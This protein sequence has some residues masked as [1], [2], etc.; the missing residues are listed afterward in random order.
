MKKI[1]SYLGAGTIPC[2]IFA[3]LFFMGQFD[4][5]SSRRTDGVISQVE[6]N[7]ARRQI[8]DSITAKYT[9]EMLA[10]IDSVERF[11]EKK[12]KRLK[13]E[14]RQLE[15][16]IVRQ[17]EGYESDSMYNDPECASV[18]QRCDSILAL[19]AEYSD[20]LV[21]TI[22]EQ[23]DLISAK[24]E[25]IAVMDNRYNQLNLSYSSA[26]LD[27]SIM[28]EQLASKNTWWARNQKWIYFVG[29]AVGAALILK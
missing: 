16:L 27:I 23:E 29:G 17:V 15:A 5:C 18:V 12:I 26:K 11:S 7:E 9:N 13:S 2:A 21:A 3:L 4:S 22:N 14:Y 6:I 20:T 25:R 24:D 19:Y 1:L 8:A 28:K 10:K